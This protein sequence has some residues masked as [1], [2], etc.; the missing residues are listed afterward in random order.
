MYISSFF[1]LSI[2]FF[3]VSANYFPMQT[4]PSPSCRSLA[5][6]S[7][8]LSHFTISRNNFKCFCHIWSF[9]LSS[10]SFHR[11]FVVFIPYINIAVPHSPCDFRSLSSAP[12]ETGNSTAPRKSF[13]PP[14]RIV[15]LSPD[16]RRWKASEADLHTVPSLRYH[17]ATMP[18][19]LPWQSQIPAAR[20]RL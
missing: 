1:S 11:P 3:L 20:W 19:S 10:L 9:F 2:S 13:W 8:F 18:P 6:R 16:N 14:P 4:W 15:R 17:R 12:K 7:A 5:E